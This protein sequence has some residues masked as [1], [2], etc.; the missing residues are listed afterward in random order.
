MSDLE[1][2]QSTLA[3]KTLLE[4]KAGAVGEPM[5]AARG[6]KPLVLIYKVMG[7]MFAILAVRGAPNVI[8]K[9]DPHLV[10]VLRGHYQGVGHRSHLDRRFWIAVDLDSDVPASEVRRLVDHSYEQVCTGLTRKQKAEL[11]ALA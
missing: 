10:E 4:A 3:L 9:C 5:T 6:S 11:E 1:L 7:K 2:G 8:L